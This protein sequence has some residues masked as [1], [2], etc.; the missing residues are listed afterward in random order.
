MKKILAFIL[1]AIMLF[2]VVACSSAYDDYEKYIELGDLKKITVEEAKILKKVAD[3]ILELRESGRKDLWVE[4]DAKTA[5][6]QKGDKLDIDYDV[7][8]YSDPDNA[9]LKLSDDTLKNMKAEAYSLILGSNSF[10]GEYTVKDDEDNVRNN[11]G[12]EDQLIGAKVNTNETDDKT[13]D[14]TVEVTVTFPDVYKDATLQKV[15]VTFKVTVNSISRSIADISNEELIASLAYT[16]TDPDA[17]ED[18][19]DDNAATPD[20]ADEEANEEAEDSKEESE[21]KDDDTVKFTDLFKNGTLKIDFSDKDELGKFNTLFDV[22]TVFEALNEKV[23]YEEIVLVFTVPTEE[24]LKA[25]E[26]DKDGND[27]FVPYAGREITVTFTL[28]GITTLPEWNDEYVKTSTSGQFEKVKDYEEDAYDTN[29]KSIVISAIIDAAVLKDVPWKEAKSAYK[30]ALKNSVI[31]AL[32]QSVNPSYGSVSSTSASVAIGDFTQKEFDKYITDDVYAALRE[33]AAKDAVTSI[34]SRL[35]YELLFD[36]LDIEI[37]GKEYKAKLKEEF[38]ANKVYYE[39]YLGITKPSKLE[40]YFGKE[41]LMI[42]F[43]HEILLDKVVDLVTI[44]K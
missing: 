30:I 17:K 32:N 14:D 21:D 15:I 34:K 43:K 13:K 7:K 31:S 35:V 4:L 6:A 20:E 24:E 2:S 26:G 29:A 1:S 44:K 38:N 22:K 42:D 27:K 25:D 36:E 5:V 8:S 40:K 39:S 16:F 10:I 23:L 12:F 11:K 33:Q 41:S 9:D 18:A 19:D 28:N 37:S 3:Q